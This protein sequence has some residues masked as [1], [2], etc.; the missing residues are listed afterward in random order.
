MIRVC[1][2]DVARNFHWKSRSDAIRA[3]CKKM[4]RKRHV[5]RAGQRLLIA[6]NQPHPL[7]GSCS[8]FHRPSPLRI[9]ESLVV[10]GGCAEFP[11]E[12]G[13]LTRLGNSIHDLIRS[14][15]YGTLHEERLRTSIGLT[16]AV[17]CVGND[18]EF[19]MSTG[20]IQGKTS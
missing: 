20:F 19:E 1:L 8:D 12:I 6:V 16:I 17:L 7:T 3:N 18:L 14:Q 13:I 15:L 11:L 5:H 9:D 2:R 10:E 4:R